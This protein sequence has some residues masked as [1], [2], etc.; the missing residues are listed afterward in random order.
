VDL[1]RAS[2]LLGV[3]ATLALEDLG[4]HLLADLDDLGDPAS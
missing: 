4:E 2:A 3:K 1:G